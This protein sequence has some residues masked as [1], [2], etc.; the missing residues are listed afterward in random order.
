MKRRLLLGLLLFPFISFSQ[1]EAEA[2]MGIPSVTQAEMLGVLTPYVGLMVFNTDAQK[3]YMYTTS[4]WQRED[5]D[6]QNALEVLLVD[7]VD[8]DGDG[9]GIPPPISDPG[10]GGGPPPS[11]AEF[12]VEDVVQ[13][14]APITSIAAR[15]F[16]PPSIEIDASTNGTFTKDLYAAYTAQFG[17]PV[18]NSFASPSAIPTYQANELY[19]YVTYADTTVF[20]T[21]TMNIDANGV[22][23]YTVIS[24]PT[25]LNALINVVFVVK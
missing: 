5:E 23:T 8:V 20:D 13:A 19:Y 10:G 6:N 24:Q 2:L 4:G 18:V 16:Y 14:I 9:F 17:S 22:L 25:N 11:G 12:N 1:I 15:I 7:P 3:I 21:A